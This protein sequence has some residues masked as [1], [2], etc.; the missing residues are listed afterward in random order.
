[1]NPILECNHVSK[2][3]GAV[4]AVDGVTL[5]I[6]RGSIVGLLGPNGSGKSTFINTT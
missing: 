4:K 3:F 2:N 6:P 1:M 5:S